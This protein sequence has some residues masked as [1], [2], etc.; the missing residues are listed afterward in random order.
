[1]ALWCVKENEPAHVSPHKSSITIPDYTFI[2]PKAVRICKKAEKV[3]A[4][5]YNR[6]TQVG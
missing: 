3:R 4:M 5:A 2:K 6:K 1:M